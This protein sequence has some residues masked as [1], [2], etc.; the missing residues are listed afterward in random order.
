MKW[1]TIGSDTK[2]DK[3]KYWEEEEGRELEKEAEHRL[4]AANGSVY[5]EETQDH[6]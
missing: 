5:W 3:S 4:P 1:L 2:C 6:P